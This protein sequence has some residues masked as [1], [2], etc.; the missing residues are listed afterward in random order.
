MKTS[1]LNAALAVAV[2]GLTAC[3]STQPVATPAA[4]VAAPAPVVAAAAPA[5]APAPVAAAA[6]VV[7]LIK[8]FY[9]VLPESGRVHAFGDLKNYRDFLNHGEVTLTRSKI[10]EGPGGATVVFGITGDDVKNNQPSLGEK[11]LSGKFAG[12]PEFYGEVL[13]NGR[14]YVFGDLKDMTDF[15]AFGEVAYGFTD[16]GE[17]PKGESLVYVMNKDSIKGGKPLNRV[18]RFKALRAATQS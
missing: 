17:G 2:L 7:E 14:Y 11:A 15:V 1:A 13:K 5:P 6:P 10:G 3:A 12:A 8:E 16:I 4:P 9:V 18:E